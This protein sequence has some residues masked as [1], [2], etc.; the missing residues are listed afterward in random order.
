MTQAEYEQWAAESAEA[1]RLGLWQIENGQ[2]IT[3]DEL[4][5]RLAD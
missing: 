3:L 2:Y 4:R 1:T 5:E